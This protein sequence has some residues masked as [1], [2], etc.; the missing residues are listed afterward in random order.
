MIPHPAEPPET[1]VSSDPTT[2][3]PVLTG[4]LLCRDLIFTT[5]ITQTAASFGCRIYVASNE[6]QAAS[7]IELSQPRVVF[8]DLTA[9]E[10]VAP[11]ALARYLKLGRADAS[12]VA[13]GPHVDAESLAAAK[14]AG[15]QSVLTRKKFT[16][17]LPELIRFYFRR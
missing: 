5:K 3:D 16:A 10:M 9:G 17:E 6:L 2:H 8:V 12:F 4:L 14:S 13:F 11:T 15:C 7:H 1:S